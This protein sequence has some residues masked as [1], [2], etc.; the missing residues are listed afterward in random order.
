MV[1]LFSNL[2]VDKMFKDGFLNICNSSIY[3]SDSLFSFSFLSNFFLEIY[4]REVDDFANKL[5]LSYCM[6]K[7]LTRSL[8]ID[9]RLPYKSLQIRPFIIRDYTPE[10]LDI[11]LMNLSSTKKVCKNRYSFL[12][13]IFKK[14]AKNMDYFEKDI[15]FVR[16]SN[17]FLF[18]FLTN[19]VSTQ[20][21]F[22][23]YLSFI[24][25]N[26][27]F[28]IKNSKVSIVKD[29]SLYFLGFQIKLIKNS[30]KDYFSFKY[31]KRS[32]KYSS[33][34]LNRLSL[35]Q[36]K[37]LKVTFNRINFE[38][39]S[40]LNNFIKLKNVANIVVEKKLWMF[41][42]QQEAVISFREGKI[43]CL[44]FFSVTKP[45]V[46]NLQK[47]S[48]KKERFYFFDSYILKAQLLVSEV[49]RDFTYSFDFQVV[50]MDRFLEK[51]LNEYKKHLFFSY[52]EIYFKDF[53]QFV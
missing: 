33:K 34:M 43:P 10:R 6:N 44:K 7:N 51:I 2:E 49:L 30:G 52:N 39:I 28:D 17:F 1:S 27:H 38:L 21:F 41:L 23:K 37:S 32:F 24:R 26:I 31:A 14:G 11:I 9:K 18:S 15:N 13:K 8:R 12:F 5:S 4:L 16:Y 42:F 50:S 19:L 3:F 20:R 40:Y 47:L 46:F 53:S 36:R 29:N 45:F 35:Y 25:S 48:V 22:R